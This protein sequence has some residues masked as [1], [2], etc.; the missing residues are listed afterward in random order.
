MTRGIV[1]SMDIEKHSV[2][3]GKMEGKDAAAVDD[4]A[5][6]KTIYENF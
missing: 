6:P 2:K 4:C 3:N 1:K 5:A